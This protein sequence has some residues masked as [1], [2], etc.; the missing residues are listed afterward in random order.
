LRI[1]IQGSTF[2]SAASY[3]DSSASMK[4]QENPNLAYPAGHYL[5]YPMALLRLSGSQVT[6]TF[7]AP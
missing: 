6:L 7:S 2:I 5:P 1:R 3:L 4:V